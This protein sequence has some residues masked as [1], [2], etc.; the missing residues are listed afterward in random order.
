MLSQLFRLRR[1]RLRNAFGRDGNGGERGHLA[2][3]N[4][5]GRSRQLDWPPLP[6]SWR[7][8]AGAVAGEMHIAEREQAEAVE[9]GGV[10]VGVEAAIVVVAAQ[11]ADLAE[12]AESGGPG[13]LA[14]DV[15][16]LIEG[17]RRAGSQQR[18]Q[19]VGRAP[20]HYETVCL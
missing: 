18:N 13:G 3:D 17:D 14:E 16:E 4:Y 15:L 11:V 20:G 7:W 10:A 2:S 5:F 19:Q 1:G 9:A 12:V 6:R 8:R